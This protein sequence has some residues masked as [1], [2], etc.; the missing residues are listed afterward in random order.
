MNGFWMMI[1][2][3]FSVVLATKNF[4]AINPISFLLKRAS[5]FSHD[6]LCFFQ[7]FFWHSVEQYKTFLQ[8]EH[9][10]LNAGLSQRTQQS[11]FTPN[12]L[13]MV[14]YTDKDRAGKMPL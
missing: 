12:P 8:M 9:C 1:S 13:G 6:T 5:F 10:W 14:V 7:C 4:P 3:H 11:G 2:S